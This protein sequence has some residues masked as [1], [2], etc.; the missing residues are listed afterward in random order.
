MER[1]EGARG[2]QMVERRTGEVLGRVRHPLF[3]YGHTQALWD[4]FG[5]S[6]VARPLVATVEEVSVSGGPG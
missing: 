6:M 3:G 5:T 1:Q 2:A 4:L